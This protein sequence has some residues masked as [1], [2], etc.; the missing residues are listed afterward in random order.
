MLN[1]AKTL[2]VGE[3]RSLPGRIQLYYSYRQ[4][5]LNYAN[6]GYYDLDSTKDYTSS[7]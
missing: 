5:Y 7:M 6:Y 2:T 3:T 4:N 1:P